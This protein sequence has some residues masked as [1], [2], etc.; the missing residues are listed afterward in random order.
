MRRLAV[1]VAVLAAGAIAGLL[2][3]H[4][5]PPAGAQASDVQ[6]EQQLACPQ[7]TSTRLDVCDRPIC[8]DMKEDIRRRLAA[9][10]SAA[11]IV[12]SYRSVYGDRVLADPA[13]P[14][15]L[16]LLAWTGLA[17]GMGIFGLLAWRRRAIPV[18]GQP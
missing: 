13:G 15:A 8:Q 14:P 4:L 1:V 5:R 17:V 12:A 2:I 3:G 16:Q 11:S 6:V 18:G 9:G 7:C 10:E